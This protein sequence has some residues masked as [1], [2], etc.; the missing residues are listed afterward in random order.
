MNLDLIMLQN[1]LFRNKN[2]CLCP[3]GTVSPEVCMMSGQDSHKSIMLVLDDIPANAWGTSNTISLYKEWYMFQELLEIFGVSWEQVYVTALTKCFSFYKTDN[4]DRGICGKAYLDAEIQRI[5]PSVIYAVGIHSIEYLTNISN[6]EDS[7]NSVFSYLDTPIIPLYNPKH[8]IPASGKVDTVKYTTQYNSIQKGVQIL[9]GV[10]KE[11]SIFD[12]TNTRIIQNIT[13]L[14]SY[15]EDI[16]R[17]GWVGFDVE[18]TGLNFMQDKITTLAISYR[19]GGALA[20]PLFHKDSP[21]TPDQIGYLIDYLNI[22]IFNNLDI[23]KCAWNIKFDLKMMQKHG[24]IF[25][26][27]LRDGMVMYHLID[28]NR[29][30]YKLEII[31]SHFYPETA[32]Y[33]INAD[34]YGG[35]D[36]V[37]LDVLA[38]YNG[39]DADVTLRLCTYFEHLLMENEEIYRN[40]RNIG[41]PAHYS[42][43]RAEYIGME[44]DRDILDK[45]C[46]EALVLM[47]GCIDKM[48]KNKYV[49]RY[50]LAKIEELKQKAILER[51]EK[52]EK[53]KQKDNKTSEKNIERWLGE[54]RKIT[55]GELRVYEGINYNS[56]PI[57]VELLFTH[58]KGFRFKLPAGITKPTTGEEVISLLKDESGFIKTLLEYRGIKKIH[59]TYL[60]GIKKHLDVNNIVHAKF[61]QN[62]TRT[63]RLS[64]SDPNLQNIPRASAYGAVV[65]EMYKAK[66]GYVLTQFDFSQAELRL[67]AI[68]SGDLTMTEAYAAGIDLHRFTFQNI[69]GLSDSEWDALPKSEQKEYRNKAKPINFGLIYMMTPAS[70]QDNA[71]N[72]YGIEMSIKEA[73]I[74]H[75][76]FF[77]LYSN[78]PKWHAK[79]IKQARDIG[80]VSTL[81]GR[82][83]HLTDIHSPVPR[84]RADAERQAVNS[85]IQGTAGEYT[86]FC[87]NLLNVI[88]PKDIYIIN[89]VHDSILLYIPKDR[90]EETCLLIKDIC[91]NAPIYEYF[92]VSLEPVGMSVDIEFGS[93]WKDLKEY[94]ITKI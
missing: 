49:V 1:S 55:T 90:F 81:F 15:I 59:S 18:T 36:N 69:Q 85:T 73:E 16:K 52:I 50:E 66:D 84:L 35:W 9:Q 89:T 67:T 76:K 8:I 25:S 4:I 71:L 91:D 43:S 83:R 88:L 24:F 5:K 40:Y 26:G 80:Y 2:C 94:K 21:F 6:Y 72:N 78:L 30:S 70:L 41:S 3:L 27:K 82:R 13:D 64:S 44:V 22:H 10:W 19:H 37:P 53:A 48:N 33:K 42:L 61:N 14:D 92:N 60:E 12:F 51:E 28:E 45:N 17:S 11:R 39:M 31:A 79:S 62:G 87:I 46:A 77:Q 86:I 38:V 63:G 65:K 58:P 20:I 54:I 29:H 23:I 56:N 93:N 34:L 75:R 32:G 68:V 57:L 74:Y 47:D 7:I